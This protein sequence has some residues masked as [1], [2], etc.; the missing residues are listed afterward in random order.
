MVEEKDHRRRGGIKDVVLAH[1]MLDPTDEWFGANRWKQDCTDKQRK[2]LQRSAWENMPQKTVVGGYPRDSRFALA[3]R[4]ALYGGGLECNLNIGRVEARS[5][6]A[7]TLQ[8]SKSELQDIW[9]STNRVVQRKIR[10]HGTSRVPAPIVKGLPPEGNNAVPLRGIT[11][12][13]PQRAVSSMT[14][15]RSDCHSGDKWG[16]H[17]QMPTNHE[18]IQVDPYEF[19]S[20]GSTFM[21]GSCRDSGP[22]ASSATG[23]QRERAKRFYQAKK[24]PKQEPHIDQG[25]LM[26]W[27]DWVYSSSNYKPN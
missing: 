19:C 6:T 10:K 16:D 13:R 24:H 7:P 15:Y 22:H 18:C 12:S 23:V 21:M 8:R 1:P 3:Q 4:G 26:K 11:R 9:G 5:R 2:S 25:R 17:R 14:S 20:M 27:A